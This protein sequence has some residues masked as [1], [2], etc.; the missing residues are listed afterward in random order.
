M[1]VEMHVRFIGKVQGVGFRASAAHAAKRLGLKGTVKNLPDGSVE[2]V[3]QGSQDNLERLVKELDQVLFPGHI[4]R[5]DQKFGPVEQD[6]SSFM[7]S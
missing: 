5:M 1:N 7:I 4:L 6:L 3:A 2:L